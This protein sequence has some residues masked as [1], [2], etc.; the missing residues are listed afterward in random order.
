MRIVREPKMGGPP[1]ADRRSNDQPAPPGCHNCVHAVYDWSDQVNSNNMGWS[2]RPMCSNHPDHSGVMRKVPGRGPCR[3]WRPKPAP[4]VR[5]DPPNPVGPRECKI[6]LTKGLFATVDPEDYEWLN[7]FRWHATCSRGRYYAATVVNGKSISMH[8]MI[9]NPPPGMQVDHK[10]TDR[11][12][13]H[14]DNLRLATAGQ[15][16]HNT[17]PSKRRKG[18][19]K[20]SQYVGVTRHG[21]KWKVKIT[22]EGQEH[23]LGYFDDE[24]E[25][26]LAWDAKAKELRGEFA[27]LNF[28][29]GPPP[30]R[31]P[32]S[33]SG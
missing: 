24:I 32:G 21:D 12:N 8:R 29:N 14:R 18:R 17:G 15:N 23:F 9:M 20:S 1:P 11:L 19:P 10:S 27:Y 5:V 25:A 7:A 13:N 6:T 4:P 33:R 30:G 16:R 26:A 3:N 28:P 22:H 31:R 2:Y